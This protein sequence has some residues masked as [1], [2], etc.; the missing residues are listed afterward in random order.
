MAPAS[1]G[2][3]KTMILSLDVARTTKLVEDMLKKETRDIRAQL[4]SF[5]KAEGIEV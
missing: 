3:V 5:A 2:P 4:A 1:I